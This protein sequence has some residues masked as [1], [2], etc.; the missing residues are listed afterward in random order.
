M[1]TYLTLFHLLAFLMAR[2]SPCGLTSNSGA[3]RPSE[4]SG[5]VR[6]NHGGDPVIGALLR[7]GSGSLERT[8]I[9]EFIFS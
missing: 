5:L 9:P 1:V 2:I 6:R 3:A 8:E 4:R 7:L